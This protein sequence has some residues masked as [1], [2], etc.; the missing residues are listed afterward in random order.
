GTADTR[1][2]PPSSRS[3]RRD[4]PAS[5]RPARCIARNEVAADACR[6]AAKRGATA[7]LL[8]SRFTTTGVRDERVNRQSLDSPYAARLIL[9]TGARP[10][11]GGED[12]QQL[13]G[14]R[15]V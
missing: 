4:G 8:V 10:R 1:S 11:P 7:G 13:A 5:R 3:R 6:S 9:R 2:R 12:A 15:A 14:C